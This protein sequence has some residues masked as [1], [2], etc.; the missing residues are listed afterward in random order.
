MEPQKDTNEQPKKQSKFAQNLPLALLLGII[1]VM[2]FAELG[3]IKLPQINSNYLNNFFGN[4]T[5]GQ[6][7][8]TSSGSQGMYGTNGDCYVCPKSSIAFTSRV[9]NSCSSGISGVYCCIIQNNNCPTW[10][11]ETSTPCHTVK[12]GIG[13]S[14]VLV[15][16]KCPN[17]PSDTEHRGDDNTAPGGPYKICLCK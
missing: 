12:N 1:L 16:A 4:H 3:Y 7:C 11:S 8:S 15:P 9:N 13:V 5:Y 14:A 2:L 17:C 6:S 10:S